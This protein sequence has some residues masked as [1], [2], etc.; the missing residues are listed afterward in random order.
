M[1][2]TE[3]R[4]TWEEDKPF[5]YRLRPILDQH[6]TSNI[7]HKQQVGAVLSVV[8]GEARKVAPQR[9]CP[10]ITLD[11]FIMKLKA[12]LLFDCKI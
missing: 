8:T 7:F 10:N 1:F 3:D 2:P 12:K 6:T 4:L 5:V 9:R 11:E